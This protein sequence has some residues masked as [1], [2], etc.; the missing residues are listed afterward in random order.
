ME[1]YYSSKNSAYT[2]GSGKPR[3]KILP[4]LNL[5]KMLGYK[6]MGIYNFLNSC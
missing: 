3:F 6:V 1:H 4:C 2:G 5:N